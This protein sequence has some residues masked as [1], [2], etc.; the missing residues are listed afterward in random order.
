MLKAM[1]QRRADQ[2][3]IQNK[4]FSAVLSAYSY[5]IEFRSTKGSCQRR[6]TV[7][8]VVASISWKGLEQPSVESVFPVSQMQAIPVS[9]AQLKQATWNGPLLS[10]VYRYVQRG[11]PDHILESLK[12]FHNC[13]TEL[14]LKGGCMLW[15]IR[16]VVPWKCRQ[17]VLDMLHEGHP[18]IVRMKSIARGYV[19]WPGLDQNLTTVA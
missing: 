5:T 12:P 8:V 4:T 11:W 15:G 17:V 1:L 19:W 2:S 13:K 9:V 10:Q 14:T 3:G 16:V 6:W 18:C 7:K